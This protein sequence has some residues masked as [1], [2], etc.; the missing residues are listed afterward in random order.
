MLYFQNIYCRPIIFTRLIWQIGVSNRASL[1]S[2]FL[3]IF[4]WMSP[5]DT[6]SCHSN[7]I[8]SRE[9]MLTN[10]D[11]R[12]NWTVTRGHRQRI[13]RREAYKSPRISAD[14]RP[15]GCQRVFSATGVIGRWRILS[16]LSALTRLSTL[17]SAASVKLTVMI[18]RKDTWLTAMRQDPRYH[19]TQILN[20]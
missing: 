8:F 18:K 12:W 6:E 2:L 20:A 4:S 19:S 1:Q 11:T 10:S 9:E 14:A 5:I 16:L 17:R 13:G 3:W 7:F 15:A